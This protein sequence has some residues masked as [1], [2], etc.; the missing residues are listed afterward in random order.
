[1]DDA[2][3]WLRLAAVPGLRMQHLAPA[4][5]QIDAASLVH[6]SVT[7]LTTLGLTVRQAQHLQQTTAALCVARQ[8]LAQSP[9]HW[10]ISFADPRYPE[11]LRQIPD[12][13][14]GLFAIGDLSCLHD[15]MLAI[16]GSRRPTATG[17]D[18]AYQLAREAAGVGLVVVSGLARGIDGA[19]HQGALEG[20]GKTVAVLGHGLQFIYPPQHQLLARQIRQQG[21]LLLS[22]FWPDQTV[23]AEFF[24]IRNRIVVGMALGT[25]VVEAALQSG[26]LISARLALEYNRDVFAMPGAVRNPQA[27]G[28]HQLIQQGAKLTCSLADILIEL[29]PQLL[30]VTAAA[31]T[32]KNSCAKGLFDHPLLSNV[33]D[34]ATD[35][36]L[37]AERAAMSVAD[38][39]IAL[40]QLELE[41]AVSV[42]PGGY[43]RVRRA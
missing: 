42:V 24:P 39:A 41:G 9:D 12:P 30:A 23:R 8:W 27:A 16:V 4:L 43:I 17:K 14:V 26:S 34:E 25:L 21:G 37:I 33:G 10:F 11:L 6:R 18:V 7:E 13:P 22:E 15:P 5:S 19:A 36:D 1:M 3:H 20:G 35:I 28:C 2:D 40:Q 38:V 29:A 32:Q 31:S